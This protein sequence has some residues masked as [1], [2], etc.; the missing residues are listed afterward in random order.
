M[1]KLAPLGCQLGKCQRH[2]AVKFEVKHLL[3]SGTEIGIGDFQMRVFSILALTWLIG[4]GANLVY[5]QDLAFDWGVR[6]SQVPGSDIIPVPHQ[7]HDFPANHIT[8]QNLY[9]TLEAQGIPITLMLQNDQGT[10]GT[11]AAVLDDVTNM[12]YVFADFESTDRYAHVDNMVS[13]VRNHSNP[14]VANAYIGNYAMYPGAYDASQHFPWIA[15]RTGVNHNDAHNFYLDS[16]LNIAQPNAYPYE[17]FTAH[18]VNW[19]V[20]QR[21]PNKRSALFYG[22]LERVSLARRSL[23]EEV[24]H[25]NDLLIP[26][27]AGAIEWT[28]YSA[29]DPTVEDHK[30]LA[31]HIRLRGADGYFTLV[32]WIGSDGSVTPPAGYPSHVQYREN[33][34]DA[35]GELDWLFAAEQA[36]EILNLDTTKTSGLEWSGMRQGDQVIFLVSNLGNAA[37]QVNFPDLPGLPDFSPIVPAGTHESFTYTLEFSADFDSDIDVDGDDFLVWQRGSGTLGTGTPTTGDANADSNI[38]GGDLSVW[39]NQYNIV[40][41]SDQVTTAVPEPASAFLLLL[42]IMASRCHLGRQKSQ[43]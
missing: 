16:G 32:S 3:V 19:P 2:M 6:N 35:W 14:E 29:P 41:V 38:D 27:L 4:F 36:P 37:N 21:S 42:G 9:S 25:E 23:N 28:G 11:L 31:Q 22:P 8:Y 30:A 5:A 33:V 39:Q 34:G 15:D 1:F 24:G 40:P 13:Q 17:Y 12:D 20:G 26:W 18:T 7:G 43:R 10:N